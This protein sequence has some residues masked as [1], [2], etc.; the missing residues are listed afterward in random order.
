MLG[1]ELEQPPFD[2]QPKQDRDKR[3]RVDMVKRD[4]R[5]PSAKRACAPDGPTPAGRTRQSRRAEQERMQG[6]AR[7][8]A[9]K[10]ARPDQPRTGQTQGDTASPVRERTPPTSAPRDTLNQK[11]AIALAKKLEAFWHGKGYLT[12]RFWAEPVGERFDKLGTNEIYRVA[13]NLVNGL[14]PRY[15]DRSDVPLAAPR[16][17][18]PS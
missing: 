5:K 9:P 1:R 13:S 18:V 15:V 11:G 14:P 16:R 12:A 6:P 4:K 10:S 7:P 3:R 2:V 8:C 17:Q